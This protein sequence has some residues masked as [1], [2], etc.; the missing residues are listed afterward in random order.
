[1]DLHGQTPK[2]KKKQVI[3][4]IGGLYASRNPVIIET[5]LGSCVAVCL[6]DEEARIGGMNHI[7]LPGKA[8]MRRFDTVARYGIN[9]MELLINRIMALGGDRGRI[10]AKVFGGAHVI[11]SI[12]LRNGMGAKNAEFALEF[13]KLENFIVV[14]S[15]L[16]GHD[17]RRVYFHTDSGDVFLKRIPPTRCPN[18]TIQERR[19]VQKVRKEAHEVGDVTLF[20]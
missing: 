16:G 10:V 1:M 13:L 4:H 2:L 5:V 14:S 6:Y 7:L 17:T 18:I 11:P 19:L 15:D 9:A 8:D 3:I 12:S 20:S